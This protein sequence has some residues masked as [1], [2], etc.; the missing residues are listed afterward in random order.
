MP[1]AT[2]SLDHAPPDRKAWSLTANP[3]VR[4]DGSPIELPVLT[5]VLIPF[6]VEGVQLVVGQI[7]SIPYRRGSLD[8]P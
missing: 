7:L 2:L 8:I 5:N 3:A 1:N 6:A 4:R